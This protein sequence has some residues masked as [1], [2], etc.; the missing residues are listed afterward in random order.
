MIKVYLYLD[1][2]S[3]R[4]PQYFPIISLQKFFTIQ[5]DL[6][7]SAR[8]T[9]KSNR[10]LIPNIS[11]TLLH[12]SVAGNQSQT[13]RMI[14]RLV[15]DLK[16]YYVLANFWK[17]SLC[18]YLISIQ[19]RTDH[20]YSFVVD[21]KVNGVRCVH[22]PVENKLLHWTLSLYFVREILGW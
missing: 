15:N 22:I 8:I 14:L 18:S 3:N 19:W 9:P 12:F 21:L 1:R 7:C 17:W 11:R 2:S 6:T 13:N 10:I 20:F 5:I 16:F 4:T